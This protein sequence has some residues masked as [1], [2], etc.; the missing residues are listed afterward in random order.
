MRYVLDTHALVWYLAQDP[1]LG[2]E[3]RKVLDDE[4]NLLIVPVI[5]L[6]EA[7]YIASRKRVPLPFSEILRWVATAPR[8][9]ILSLDVFT[10]AHFPDNL[11]IH[12]GLIVAAALY[13]REFFG[14]DITLLTKDLAI[15]QSGLLPT[16][17]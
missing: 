10:L 8:C 2:R 4:N 14:D 3:A 17:W 5:V 11:D 6:A 1:R 12:D 15:T 13:S 9:S 16:L 7:K